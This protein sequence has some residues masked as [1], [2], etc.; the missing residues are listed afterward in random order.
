M[1]KHN[2]IFQIEDY[3]MFTHSIPLVQFPER[4]NIGVCETY[5]I[6]YFMSV[7]ILGWEFASVNRTRE[8]F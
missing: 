6:L 4:A 3:E 7:F 5:R 1:E 2:V 8:I